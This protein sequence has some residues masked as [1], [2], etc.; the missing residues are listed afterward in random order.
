MKKRIFSVLMAFVLLQMSAMGFN[1]PVQWQGGPAPQPFVEGDPAVESFADDPAPAPEAA[2][3]MLPDES[4]DP[5]PEFVPGVLPADGEMIYPDYASMVD[6]FAEGLPASYDTRGKWQTP[7]QNQGS[8]GLCWAFGTYA[9]MEANMQ[10]NRVQNPDFSELHMG[11]SLSDRSGNTSQGFDRAPNAG[12]NRYMSASYLMRDTDLSGTIDE[13]ADPYIK[14]VVKERDLS[15]SQSK[16]KTYQ[17]QNI[18]YL[19]GNRDET[20]FNVMKQAVMEYGGVGAYIFFQGQTT[21]TDGSA[22]QA[23]FNDEYNAYCYMWEK[24]NSEKKPERITDINHVVE[25][26]GWND[27]YPK[28]NFNA[29]ARPQHNG[30]WL[31]KNSWGSNW[32]DHGYFWV[33]YEDTSFP[34]DAFCF[35]GVKEYD[36][37]EIV[38]ETDYCNNGDSV[39]FDKDRATLKYHYAKTFTKKTSGTEK[40]QS[41]RVLI[42]HPY[43]SV[44]IGYR[45]GTMEGYTFAP[46][47][48]I[49]SR[50]TEVF[51]P[52]W[53]TVPFNTPVTIG[54]GK[55]TL[56]AV[57]LRVTVPDVE[58][59]GDGLY[60][61]YDAKNGIGASDAEASQIY[62]SGNGSSWR[63]NNNY[64]YCIKA[65]TKPIDSQIQGQVVLEK[66]EN[67]LWLA[68][69]GENQSQDKVLTDLTLPASYRGAAISWIS[70]N[71][72]V[73]DAQGRV[74]RPV[75][76]A[77]EI[78]NLT[79]TLRSGSASKNVSFNLTVSRIPAVD[80]N[81]V[82]NVAD[83]ITW[84][85]IRGGNTNQGNVTQ[86]LNL[87]GSS[88]G[89]TVV[90]TSS[91]N[92]II[93]T[94]K[95]SGSDT[96]IGTVTLARFDKTN[97]VALTATVTKGE[98]KVTK[99]FELTV[100]HREASDADKCAAANEW[101]QNDGL[102]Y[103]WDQVKGENTDVKYIRHDFVIPQ[104][105]Q[106][107]LP[108]L[109]PYFIQLRGNA[110]RLVWD[111][112]QNK[113]VKWDLID[114][115]GKVTRP[116]YGEPDV[117]GWFYPECIQG[118]WL[119]L[120]Y[121]TIL[122]YKG[123]ITAGT[124]QDVTANSGRTVVLKANAS[125]VGRPGA[126]AYQWYQADGTNKGNAQ[127]LE[128]ETF[129]ELSVSAN[130]INGKAYYYCE[131]SGVDAAPVQTNVATVTK[132]EPLP[133]SA[134]L[135][136]SNHMIVHLGNI[137]LP[138]SAVVFAASYDSSGK[139]KTSLQ[140]IANGNTVT[141]SKNVETGWKLF[142]LDS[143][144]RPLCECIVLH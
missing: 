127:K 42:A 131:I 102:S 69:R 90:W 71:A 78:V 13:S 109:A 96:A 114:E 47:G 80:M 40:L 48:G 111:P 101:L 14:T 35:D 20:A 138:D 123:A 77:D 2:E 104:K 15:V 98:A 122:A 132:G 52:G 120:P 6:L 85:S 53:Y 100:P 51:S 130:S 63:V 115:K 17:A 83:S 34:T 59:G 119:R 49:G 105:I 3:K 116:A 142:C 94:E 112:D 126:L 134:R 93:K 141:F 125:T 43:T 118:H 24:D 22:Q 37:S 9:A 54:G 46:L 28:E 50:G 58:N 39:G 99:T 103:W 139:M 8:N 25:I 31:V 87:T 16:E 106:I 72:Q 86:D 92:E 128:G 67:G 44:E 36:N 5:I 7:V 10:K 117:G 107:N 12:G 68:I 75:A 97:Q 27:D 32:G 23:F 45:Q 124:L 136:A 133:V 113:H 88:G 76:N 91:D 84:D 135:D 55:G 121:V 18:L 74:M 65:V 140:G 79:A 64:N 1:G 95:T 30:A 81:A 4:E 129:T 26:A 73:I 61:G 70:S 11:Y 41:V 66:A 21:A 29:I 108:G 82:Q 144:D 137:T 33:S 89:V 60:M 57:T 62:L 38:Y 19:T 143:R 56:F 110:D